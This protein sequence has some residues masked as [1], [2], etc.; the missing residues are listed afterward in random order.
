[1]H[2]IQQAVPVFILLI[3]IEALLSRWRGKS[4]YN[5]ADSIT[6]LST[7]LLFS[8]AGLLVVLLYLPLWE[9]LQALSRTWF[10]P[11][12]WKPG[13]AVVEP[14]IPSWLYWLLLLLLVDFFYYWFH[15]AA[16]E[17]RFLWACHVTHHSSEEFNLTV[18]LRQ[19][20]FQRLFEY[21]FF[22]LLA[23]AQIPWLD[24]LLCHGILK[25]YQ[26]W[27]HTRFIPQLGLLEYVFLT[28]S[29]HR[30]HHA[31]HAPYLDKNHGGIL[32]LWDMLFGTYE[33]E[34]IEPAYG[35]TKAVQTG[36][37]IWLN[38]HEYATIARRWMQYSWKERVSLLFRSPAWK[39]ERRQQPAEQQAPAEI[40]SDKDPA[41]QKNTIGWPYMLVQFAL[42]M[43]VTLAVLR[44]SRA[45]VS[46][47]LLLP[48][49]LWAALSLYS[50][51]AIREGRALQLELIRPLLLLPV[52]AWF[53]LGQSFYQG[54]FSFLSGFTELG[55]GAAA[56]IAIVS[57][58]AWLKNRPP[59]R[60]P[61]GN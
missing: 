38:I 17:I 27:V 9:V 51:N 16:H 54:R 40:A 7:A 3:L 37:P 19:C 2:L 36:E 12:Q 46:G 6:N 4:F 47:W 61:A 34:S 22:L 32:I 26:F 58:F 60:Q 55:V 30:V 8:L 59:A 43:A 14:I 31:S 29:H 50:I 21:S 49:G 18:A 28:P 35:L 57:L 5:L 33:K 13:S 44:L 41:E 15:R 1:M 24:F 56:A 39:P 48:A 11:I 42:I 52:A 23:L 53:F 25:L 45:G 10:G 20:S